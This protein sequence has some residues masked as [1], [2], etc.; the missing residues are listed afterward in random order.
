MIKTKKCRFAAVFFSGTWLQLGCSRD[1][2]KA[3]Q[4]PTSI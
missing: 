1:R 3:L 4:A 2:A